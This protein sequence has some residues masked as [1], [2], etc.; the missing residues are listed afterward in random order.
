M[1]RGVHRHRRR[2]AGRDPGSGS[3]VDHQPDDARAGRRA[4]SR[5]HLRPEQPDDGRERR[6]P[7]LQPGLLHHLGHL[8]PRQLD[9][10]L[11]PGRA[12]AHLA[13][14]PRLHQHRVVPLRRRVPLQR[15][16]SGDDR[17]RLQPLGDPRRL[18]H[19]G[20][21]RQRRRARAVDVQG[22]HRCGHLQQALRAG[23]DRPAA[24]RPEGQPAVPARQR[25]RRGRPRRPVLLDGRPVEGAD[26]GAPRHAG[27]RGCRAGARRHL[28][29]DAQ[30]RQHRR[31]DARV[32][33][34]EGAP[35]GLRPGDGSQDLAR[36]TPI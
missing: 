13:L 33:T 21:D 16:R 35:E 29:R 31:G 17:A 19:A 3:R 23:T 30:G 14:Q 26:A 8:Q 18:P 36:S 27:A 5:I 25:R 22:H 11:V 9:G 1:G 4:R 20:E 34:A 24:A 32:R 28:H 15:R 12:D 7:G 6:V 2:D 10:R